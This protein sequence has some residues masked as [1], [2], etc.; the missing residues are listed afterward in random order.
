MKGVIICG[1]KGTRMGNI[2][3][4]KSLLEVGG[5][6][7]LQHQ[8]EWFHKHGIYSIII[9]AGHLSKQ[10]NSFVTKHDFELQ[11]MGMNIYVQTETFPL[12]TAGALKSAEKMLDDTA[13]VIY[14]DKMHDISLRRMIDFHERKPSICTI[15]LHPTS[16]M[17]DSD[18]VDINDDNRIV[19]VFPKPHD[20]NANYRNLTNICVYIITPKIFNYIQA[21]VFSDFAKDVL[22]RLVKLERTYGYI[23]AEYM[24]DVGTPERLEKVNKDFA[25]GKITNHDTKRKAVFLDRDGVIVRRCDGKTG[26]FDD[27]KTPDEFELFPDVIPAIKMINECGYLAIVITNQPGV[28]KNLFSIDTL[29]LIHNKMETLLGREGAK[30]DGIYTCPH[31]PEKG[32]PDENPIY[33]IDCDC[34]KPKPGLI[35]RAVEEFNIDV[36]GSYMIGDNWYDIEC[37]RAAGVKTIALLRNKNKPEIWTKSWPDYSVNDL[38]SAVNLII[39]GGEK[40]CIDVKAVDM[41]SQKKR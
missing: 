23:T 27:V 13:V 11:K 2:S 7:L 34:R 1:G 16:H 30:L 24:Y 9:L 19:N 25:T 4:P 38:L 18:L 40:G 22:P 12:G 32:H 15:G 39:N 20:P 26:D 33:K 31:H 41:F 21:G 37:G 17:H 36:V 10:I 29:A 5:K 3:V 28:A 35:N 8:I 6:P 14:G